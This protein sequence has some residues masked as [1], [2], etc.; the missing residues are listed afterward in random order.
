MLLVGAF[1]GYI[2]GWFHVPDYS[3]TFALH[4]YY[5]VYAY[6]VSGGIITLS[7]YILLKNRFQNNKKLIMNL[8][9]AAAVSCYYWFRLPQLFGF[10]SLES[11][12]ILVN[13]TGYLPAWSMNIL[14]LAT[15][16]LF[17]WWMVI[18]NKKY[19]SWSIRPAYKRRNLTS[20]LLI[21]KLSLQ[22]NIFQSI[23]FKITLIISS[24]SPSK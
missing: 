6:P 2:W 11:N 9:A 22:E 10:S 4:N 19:R 1:P 20:S 14:N 24:V 15:T 21:I 17:V 8:F 13:L 23:S 12:G 16:T 3:A 5:I 7:L 18:A